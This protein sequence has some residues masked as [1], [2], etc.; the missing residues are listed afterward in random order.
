MGFNTFSPKVPFIA[1]IRRS[2]FAEKFVIVIPSCGL[3]LENWIST[4]TFKAISTRDWNRF[5]LIG[6]CFWLFNSN[7]KLDGLT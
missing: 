7:Y 5:D 1:K 6:D 4:Q 3:F 2:M